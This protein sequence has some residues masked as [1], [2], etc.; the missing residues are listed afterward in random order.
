MAPNITEISS[1]AE[2]DNIVRSLQ[3]A[4]LLVID[5]HAVWCG[6]CHAIA[7]VL[8]QLSNSYKHVKFVKIDVDKQ[9]QLAQRFRISAMPTFKFLKGGREIDELKGASPPQLNQLISRHAGPVPSASAP[10][11]SSSSSNTKSAPGDTTESLLKHIISNGLNCL[12]ESSSHPLSSIVGPSPGPRGTSYLESDVDAELLISIPFQETVK[13]RSISIF[14]AI[15]PSQAPKEIKL[16]INTPNIDFADTE[17]LTP[18]QELDLTES[19]VKG[20]KIEL[21]FVRFQS[22]R[23]LH[24]LV[25]SNQEDEETTRIDSIDIF[26]TSGDKTAEK[27]AAPQEGGGGGGSMLEKLMASRK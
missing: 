5:F 12:N 9:Q 1:T 25:K 23:S 27:P 15:S 17:N 22:V 18:A 16:F 24:I 6:P 10:V 20:D 13:I 4:Q 3:P 11:T 19:Q 8:E 21:R 26:G 7:P 14:S 2:F